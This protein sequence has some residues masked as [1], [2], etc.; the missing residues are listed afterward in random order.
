MF[1][2]DGAA[3]LAGGSYTVARF[4]DWRTNALLTSNP[5]RPVAPAEE[6]DGMLA[7]T[8]AHE[9]AIRS[10]IM[11]GDS[12]VVRIGP[13]RVPVWVNRSDD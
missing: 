1:G 2:T 7:A 13:S 8:I 3:A 4:P 10:G 12:C 9:S 11:P 6:P 5:I